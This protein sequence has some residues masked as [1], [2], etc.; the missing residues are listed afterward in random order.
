MQQDRLRTP[1][2]LAAIV[3]LLLLPLPAETRN[4]PIVK[5]NTADPSA[6][7]WPSQP[8]RLWIYAS[9]DHADANTYDTMDQYWVY[10][11]ND[12]LNW[13]DHGLA[14]HLDNVTW[15]S[16]RVSKQP[17]VGLPCQRQR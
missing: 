9:H 10:S 12:M 1:L 2:A 14:L 15:A 11:T 5:R 7:I 3:L 16:E 17:W 6:H 4:P 8:D 13:H